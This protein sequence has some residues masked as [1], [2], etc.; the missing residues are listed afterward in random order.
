MYSIY[1]RRKK[2]KG[3]SSDCLVLPKVDCQYQ[4]GGEMLYIFLLINFILL[5]F[6]V[7]TSF[8]SLLP[9]I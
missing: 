6:T 2:R 4:Y 9:A 5:T 7:I 3:W 1:G 8:S